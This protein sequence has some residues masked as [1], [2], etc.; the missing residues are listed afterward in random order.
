MNEIHFS[1]DQ[2]GNLSDI[3]QALFDGNPSDPRS[4]NYER[5]L[6]RPTIKWCRILVFSALLIGGAI[7]L[8]Y[9]CSAFGLPPLAAFGVSLTSA[10]VV[11]VLYLKSILICLVMIYQYFA[12]DSLRN[13]C[14]FEPS[15][16]QYMIMS[17]NKYGIVKGLIKGINR[18]KR[19]NTSD[20]GFDYP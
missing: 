1:E 2:L 13:K 18:L 17:L 19:C 5:K 3:G 16:S 6:I 8:Y 15:C 7:G 9:L 4:W 10:V 11:I 12:P 20:G 14:R